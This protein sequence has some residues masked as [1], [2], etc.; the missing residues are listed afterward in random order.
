MRGALPRTDGCM[1]TRSY[2]FS[3]N[4]LNR[5]I[6]I[7]LNHYA[8]ATFSDQFSSPECL[9]HRTLP[10]LFDL[11][12]SARER[13]LFALAPCQSRWRREGCLAFATISRMILRRLFSF[14]L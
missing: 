9:S 2:I 14:A 7:P 11:D 10:S 12:A 6:L 3:L 1:R 5:K 4:R 13:F 8:A